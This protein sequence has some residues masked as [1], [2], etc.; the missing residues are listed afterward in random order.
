ML[1]RA[2]KNRLVENRTDG[3]GSGADL[4]YKE[5]L[6]DFYGFPHAGDV[7]EDLGHKAFDPDSLSR[8]RYNAA[9][10]A[11]SRAT[12]RLATRGL[13]ELVQGR[14]SHWSGV[15]LTNEGVAV[16]ARIGKL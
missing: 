15:N 3:T 12:T 11:T 13:V 9:C 16:V 5:V 2:H 7:R 1:E 4:Y 14:C 8:A 6:A 10:A